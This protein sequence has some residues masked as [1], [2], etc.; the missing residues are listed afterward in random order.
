MKT[1]I[2]RSQDEPTLIEIRKFV[3]EGVQDLYNG[4]L[5]DFNTSFEKLEKRYSSND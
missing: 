3:N 1:T 4:N 2:K 5:L